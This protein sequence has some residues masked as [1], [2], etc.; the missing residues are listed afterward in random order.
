MK[1]CS[2]K[3]LYMNVH[4]Q[5]ILRRQPWCL[6]TDEKI[7]KTWFFHPMEHSSTIK[8]N[9]QVTQVTTW[10]NL[11]FIILHERIQIKKRVHTLSVH[12]YKIPFIYNSS[13]RKQISGCLW[14]GMERNMIP[15][16]ENFWKWWNLPASWLWWWWYIFKSSWNCTF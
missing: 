7:N 16:E 1:I 3:T 4:S 14:M 15:K 6:S 2:H 11:E 13:D 8:S 12:L 9:K 5:F 10:I